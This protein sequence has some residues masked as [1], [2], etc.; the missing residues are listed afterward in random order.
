MKTLVSGHRIQK[1]VNYSIDY[2]RLALEECIDMY[3]E[4]QG[5]FIGMSG[6]ASGVDLWFCDICLCRKIPYQA[7]IPFIEQSDLMS[8]NDKLHREFLIKHSSQLKTCRNSHMV[9]AAKQGIIVWDGNKGGTHS[10][11]QQMIEG[12]KPFFWINPVSENIIK[13][14]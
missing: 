3:I 8:E 12:E 1:L 4:K 10:V 11:F 2:I 9:F 6:M 5:G 14:N 7:W 13:V